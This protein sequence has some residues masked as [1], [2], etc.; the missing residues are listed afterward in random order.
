MSSRNLVSTMW[1]IYFVSALELKWPFRPVLVFANKGPPKPGLREICAEKRK[2]GKW[3]ISCAVKRH[4]RLTMAK[5]WQYGLIFFCY[6]QEFLWL[7]I[8]PITYQ[9]K[10]HL[11]TNLTFIPLWSPC[12]S[13]SF[14][15]ASLRKCFWY[16]TLRWKLGIYIYD[17][18]QRFSRLQ[19]MT[20]H[21][22]GR[23]VTRGFFS[24]SNGKATHLR[25][26]SGGSKYRK[27]CKRSRKK[28]ANG[29]FS[30]A[31]NG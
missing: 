3:A 30:S 17:I 20:N 10:C 16:A 15:C 31:Q 18:S 13:L 28:R 12:G 1:P 6:L 9:D 11:S 23:H 7:S 24:L 8:F 14:Q 19:I 25:R 21:S 22:H 29:S 4:Y 2:R 27:F 5:Q 26:N